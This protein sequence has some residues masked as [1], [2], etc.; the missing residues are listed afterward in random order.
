MTFFKLTGRRCYE[1]ATNNYTSLLLCL[2]TT[3]YPLQ[4]LS[5]SP[6]GNKNHEHGICCGKMLKIYHC[7]TLA[8]R[9]RVNFTASK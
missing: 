4:Y 6:D 8:T 7:A 2:K 3:A 9:G 5:L 1:K